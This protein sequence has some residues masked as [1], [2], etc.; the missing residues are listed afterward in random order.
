M[1]YDEFKDLCR[2]PWEEDFNYLCIDRC[3]RR[4]KGRYCTCKE[5]KKTFIKCTPETKPFLL[6]KCYIQLKIEKFRKIQTS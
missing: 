1:S 3:K 4:E 5:S 2:K 6:H